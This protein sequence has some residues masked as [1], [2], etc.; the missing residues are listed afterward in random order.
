MENL[1]NFPQST[2]VNKVVPKNAFYGR[3][4]LFTHA[5][6]HRNRFFFRFCLSRDAGRRQTQ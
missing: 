3:S 6:R 1:L 5:L 4:G 2:I